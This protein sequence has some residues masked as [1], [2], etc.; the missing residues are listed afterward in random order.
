MWCVLSHSTRHGTNLIKSSSTT[1]IVKTWIGWMSLIRCVSDWRN[2]THVLTSKFTAAGWKTIA[3]RSNG[4]HHRSLWKIAGKNIGTCV[5][6]VCIYVRTWISIAGSS[7]QLCSL[8]KDAKKMLPLE[9]A[10]AVICGNPSTE[11]IQTIAEDMTLTHMD[12]S[13]NLVAPVYNYWLNKRQR[14][15]RPLNLRLKV[16]NTWS[17]PGK[18]SLSTFYSSPLQKLMIRPL[19]WHSGHENMRIPLEEYELYGIDVQKSLTKE[20][21]DSTSELLN[22]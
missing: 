15:A 6:L 17:S 18:G 1:L 20:I 21:F 5:E 12:I 2:I 16:P 7:Y 3:R 4:I 8:N 19:W 10:E 11:E 22:K 13:R 14:L 9:E